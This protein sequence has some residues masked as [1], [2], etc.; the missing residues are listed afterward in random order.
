MVSTRTLVYRP[1][2][3][4]PIKGEELLTLTVVY[5]PDLSLIGARYQ[6]Q[7]TLSTWGICRSSP[8]FLTRDRKLRP[9]SDGFISRKELILTIK[10][11]NCYLSQGES[12]TEINVL[13]HKQSSEYCFDDEMLRK[14]VVVSLSGRVVLLLHYRS[15]IE[16]KDVAQL[17]EYG[18]L[19]VSENT[20]SVR[21]LIRKVASLKLPILIRGES[22]TG[23][24]VVANAIH[25]M[26]NRKKAAF[27][28]INMASIPKDLVSSELFGSVKGAFTGAACRD[29]YFQRANNGCLFLDEIGEAHADVQVALLRALE[30]GVVQAVGSEK[31][32][33]LNVRI[34]AAT[35]ANL[36]KL[37]GIDS[38]K[39]PLLQ[40]LSGVVVEL[41]PLRKRV[42]DFGI[43]FSHFL[44][45]VLEEV[46][47]QDK[48]V[49]TEDDKQFYWA[50]LF[51]Q[52]CQLNWPGNV[53]QLK[54]VTTQLA[55][56]LLGYDNFSDFDW[57]GFVKSIAN[58]VAVQAEPNEQ[59]VS[60]VIE[61][62]RKPREITDGEIKTVL[63]KH[64]WQ[65]KQTAN[66]LGI[67]RAALYL[68]IDACSELHR[69]NKLTDKQLN[70]SFIKYRGDLNQMV[71]ELKVSRQALKR[72][73]SEIGAVSLD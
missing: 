72:R 30:T 71:P 63:A 1:M 9:L 62:K 50:W 17:D 59:V 39:M 61:N 11:S 2:S 32:E 12:S 4:R 47:Q 29:G 52:F 70:S 58:E 43:L 42:D 15:A 23:K 48:F 25:K 35:D 14:G 27:I 16:K 44:I 41:S 28:S 56:A 10:G 6:P 3:V 46:G 65:I 24:E 38:F 34:I 36:E 69:A 31:C 73:L 57:Y 53:R 21:S 22:G 40:R 26:G 5:H 68:R 13:N 51:A 54:N 45:E 18:L 8:Q 60:K 49:N 64:E 20:L 33:K 37:I 66:E 67:S 19:G 7:S 55:V